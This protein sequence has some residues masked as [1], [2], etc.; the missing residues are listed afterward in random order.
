VEVQ[1]VQKPK[2]APKKN[3]SASKK[4]STTKKK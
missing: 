2:V 1:E 4:G 3:S